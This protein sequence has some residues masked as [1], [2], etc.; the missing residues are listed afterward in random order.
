MAADVAVAPG[1]HSRRLWLLGTL[2]ATV[3][4]IAV[5]AIAAPASTASPGTGL[6]W[7]L[8]V[9]SSVHVA[10]TGWFYSVREVR[11]HMR[12]HKARYYLVPGALVVVAS[13]LAIVMSTRQL[14]WVL[15]AFFAWQFFHFQKQNLGVAALAAR[16]HHAR[17]LDSTERK[18][19]VGAGIGG[20]VGLL[21][22]PALLQVA[23]ARPYEFAFLV[24]AIGFGCSAAVGLWAL[25]RRPA[26][27]RPLPY[28]LAYATSLLFFAPVWSFASP[29]G[30]VA[31]LTIAHGLQYLILM[32]LLAARPSTQRGSALSVLILVNV[33]VLLGLLLNGMSHLHDAAGAGRL[34]FG[35]YL[36]LSMSHFV[37]DAGLWRL[38]DE[39]PRTF[40]ADKLP[41]LL[42]PERA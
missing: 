22:H 18:A 9:G 15:L 4:P 7:V 40:L 8:F 12:A 13:A 24:G 3:V 5:L 41:F 11:A 36:G 33:A 26:A 19:L 34:L 35:V 42:A 1:Q 30:A 21:G 10:S 17:G 27:D 28:V 29:Y 25:S 32:G 23:G 31:G 2:V 14:V 20:I 37:V 39:F 16:A 6:A 38:R